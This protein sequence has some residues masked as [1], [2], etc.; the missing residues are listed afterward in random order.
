MRPRKSR[1]AWSHLL[2][3]SPRHPPRPSREMRDSRQPPKRQDANRG[4][5]LFLS[6]LASWRLGG[7]L[8]LFWVMTAAA[9]QAPKATIEGSVTRAGTGQPLKGA[10]VTLSRATPAAA[11]NQNRLNI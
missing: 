8:L 1:S 5:I 4:M 10:K 2:Q 7:C 6:L 9:A 11:N 3:R